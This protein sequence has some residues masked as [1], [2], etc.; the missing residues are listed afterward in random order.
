MNQKQMFY[1]A[2]RKVS[3]TNEAFLDLVKDG[4]TKEDLVRN[5]ERR[6]ALW[7]RFESF[8]NTLPSSKTATTAQA[9]KELCN[10]DL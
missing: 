7:S 8:I 2:H 3:D 10:A 5:I 6:P 9:A 1:Q 4:L